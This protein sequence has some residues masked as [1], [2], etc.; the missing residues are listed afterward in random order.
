MLSRAG[1]GKPWLYQ[2]LLTQ[3]PCPITQ[4]EK[5]RL[6]LLHL[7]GLATL[8]NESKAILQSKSLVRYYFRH[9]DAKSL[10]SFYQLTTLDAISDWL[11]CLELSQ[12]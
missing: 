1:S 4:A 5:V 6:F 10:Q 11:S 7:Q 9:L 2:T 12:I 3:N 8:E